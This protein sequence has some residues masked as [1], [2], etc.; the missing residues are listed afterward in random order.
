MKNLCTPGYI[1]TSSKD[2]FL[3][4]WDLS[5]QHCIQTIVAHRAEIWTLDINNEQNLLF[6]GS[7]EGEL[8]AWKIDHEVLEAGLKPL[9]TGEVCLCV[10]IW[11]NANILI[12]PMQIPKAIVP[13]ATLP[14]SSQHRVSQISFHPSQPYVAVQSHDRSVEIFRIRTEDEIRKKQARRKKRAKEKKEKS[15][16][17]GKKEDEADPLEDDEEGKV[18]LVDLFTPYLVVRATGKIRS[19]GF[20]SEEA[21]SKG[22]TQVCFFR[23]RILSVTNLFVR[24][25]WRCRTMPWKFTTSRNRRRRKRNLQKLPGYIR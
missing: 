9:E 20:E 6:T 19:F 25:L 21:T 4:L 13:A 24:Y 7:G 2:T 8:K 16:G 12:S 15:K 10:A 5:T 3:K 18:D 1:L 23:C 14:L 17:K 11:R 22:G